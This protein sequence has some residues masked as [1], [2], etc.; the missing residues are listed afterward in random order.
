MCFRGIELAA[1]AVFLL[2]LLLP[3]VDIEKGLRSYIVPNTG[4]VNFVLSFSC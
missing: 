2:L 1:I 4:A 3:R